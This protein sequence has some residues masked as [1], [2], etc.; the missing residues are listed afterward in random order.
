MA[1]NCS[2]WHEEQTLLTQYLKEGMTRDQV[3]EAFV[4][5]Y[6]S[7][8]VLAAPIDRGFNRL[9]WMLPYAAGLAGV[10]TAG[11]FAL[12]WAR[13][14]DVAPPAAERPASNPALQERL[15]DELRELD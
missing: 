13:R 15:D 4:Q 5:K 9:L 1:P 3:I 6:G 14:R 10:V 12:K 8:E 7:Q 2:H 11:G